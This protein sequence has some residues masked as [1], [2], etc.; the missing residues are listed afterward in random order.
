MPIWILDENNNPLLYKGEDNENK[1]DVKVFQEIYKKNKYCIF[2]DSQPNRNFDTDPYIKVYNNT[3]QNKA[4]HV[5]RVSMKDGRAIYHRNSGKDAGKKDLKYTKELANFLKDAMDKPH[6]ADIPRAD[7][8][9]VYDAIYYY[10][11]EDYKTYIQYPVPNFT[12]VYN[13]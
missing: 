6:C 7:I 11:S 12:E 10:I 13:K 9:T 3:D 5:L 2:S 4:T 8:I 1:K